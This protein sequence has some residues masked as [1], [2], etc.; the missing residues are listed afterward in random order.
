MRFLS[1]HDNPVLVE[2][3]DRRYVATDMNDKYRRNQKYF[4]ELANAVNDP[5]VQKMYFTY[6]I[7]RDL[8]KFS[9]RDIPQTIRRKK[10]KE[11][12]H[13]NHII[14]YLIN[15]VTEPDYAWWYHRDGRYFSC[16]NV[17]KD[18]YETYCDANAI[19]RSY[20][21]W[22]AIRSKLQSYKFPKR[23]TV[24]CCMKSELDKTKRVIQCYEITR[25]TVRALA[26]RWF[27]DP[28]WNYPRQEVALR[29]QCRF[30]DIGNRKK[31]RK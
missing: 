10:L 26:Q 22:G 28:Q 1:N 7:N 12:N 14:H 6:L 19:P 16:K 20:Q 13:E 23:R 18:F 4:K 21:R 5:I 9:M 15:V 24:D 2:N 11:E 31:S 27:D 29:N 25:N 17:S 30:F 8:S 3:D